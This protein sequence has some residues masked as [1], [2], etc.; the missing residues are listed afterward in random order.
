MYDF[1]HIQWRH[2][3]NNPCFE[4]VLKT[5]YR[6]FPTLKPLL[7]PARLLISEKKLQPIQLLGP[8]AF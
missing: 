4:I 6:P 8:H 7:R 3:L 5:S 1:G 2:F